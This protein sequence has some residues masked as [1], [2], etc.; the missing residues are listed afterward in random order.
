MVV[1][2]FLWVEFGSDDRRCQLELKGAPK[3][4]G[5][6]EEPLTPAPTPAPPHGPIIYDSKSR[7]TAE[8]PRSACAIRARARQSAQHR[9]LS[10]SSLLLFGSSFHFSMWPR[11]GAFELITGSHLATVNPALNFGSRLEARLLRPPTLTS[12]VDATMFVS[13]IVRRENT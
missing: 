10:A 9:I 1:R 11:G 12:T 2:R 4:F 6:M 8:Q 7:V 3:V 13:L 5:L